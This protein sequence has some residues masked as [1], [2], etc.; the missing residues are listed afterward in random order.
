MLS[1]LLSIV[2]E[3]NFSMF[4]FKVVGFNWYCRE[5]NEGQI[6][7]VVWERYGQILSIEIEQKN[8]MVVIVIYCWDKEKGG[9]SIL[10][11][12]MN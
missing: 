9:I 11:N 10:K 12:E 4:L 2:L 1:D 8:R 3:L 5:E 6:M 7:R